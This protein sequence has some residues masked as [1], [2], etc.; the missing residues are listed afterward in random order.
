M[1]SFAER[2]RAGRACMPCSGLMKPS[3][4]LAGRKAIGQILVDAEFSQTRE[5]PEDTGKFKWQMVINTELVSMVSC[6]SAIPLWVARQLRKRCPQYEVLILN[7]DWDELK[8]RL[9]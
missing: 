4:L 5:I 6:P 1:L 8:V 9:A 7:I 2:S 3:L